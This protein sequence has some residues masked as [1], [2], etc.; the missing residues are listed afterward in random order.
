LSV[1]VKMAWRNIWRNPRRSVL[2]ILAIAFASTLLVFML[3][4][5]FGSYDTMINASVKIPYFY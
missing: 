3:S 2:T 5:Q 1:D 4:W